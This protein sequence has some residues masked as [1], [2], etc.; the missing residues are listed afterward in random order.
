M[1]RIQKGLL[2]VAKGRQGQRPSPA[3][4]MEIRGLPDL[5]LEQAFEALPTQPARSRSCAGC[6]IKLLRATVAGILSSNVALLKNMKSPAG[7]DVRPPRMAL[8]ACG[9]G[10]PCLADPQ[11]MA[12]R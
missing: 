9:D 1:W 11:L 12:G 8:A 3:R 7:Y 5:K 10:G 4:I 2:T 6:T